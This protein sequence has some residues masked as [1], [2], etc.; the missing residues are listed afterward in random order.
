MK[1]RLY[2]HKL[3]YLSSEFYWTISVIICITYLKKHTTGQ[4]GSVHIS[5]ACAAFHG[6]HEAVNHLESYLLVV[7]EQ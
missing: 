4:K 3:T 1:D 5:A 6:S 7:E 2:I